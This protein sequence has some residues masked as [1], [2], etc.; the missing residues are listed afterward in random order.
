MRDIPQDG[1]YILTEQISF[2]ASG[3]YLVEQAFG[4]TGTSSDLGLLLP[5]FYEGWNIGA[6]L[7]NLGGSV[8]F[9]SDNPTRQYLGS[10]FESTSGLRQNEYYYLDLPHKCWDLLHD[11]LI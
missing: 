11:N 3:K 2:H 10:S 9:T 7:I 5:E 4:G 1:S 6:S 8:K